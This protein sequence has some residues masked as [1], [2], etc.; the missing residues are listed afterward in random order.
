MKFFIGEYIYFMDSDDFLEFDVFELCYC[1][2]IKE[3]FDFV[4]F[5]VEMFII[6][7]NIFESFFD[8]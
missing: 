6:E 4:F 3:V 1:K 2:C 5:D 7:L 8:Y